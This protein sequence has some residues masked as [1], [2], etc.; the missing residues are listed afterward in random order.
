MN[1]RLG[2]WDIPYIDPPFQ[3]DADGARW[4]KVTTLASEAS[5][6]KVIHAVNQ[7]LHDDDLC[8]PKELAVQK[9]PKALVD[10]ENGKCWHKKVQAA[11]VI[12]D[13]AASNVVT[14][15]GAWQDH[16]FIYVVMEYCSKVIGEREVRDLYTAVACGAIPWTE[17]DRRRA[18]RQMLLALGSLHS[19][20]LTHPELRLHHFLLSSTGSIKLAG[21][22]STS[23]IEVPVSAGPAG[24]A[25]GKKLD[26][27]KLGVALFA[28]FF[29]QRP[30][31]SMRLS[32]SSVPE[33][34]AEDFVT[35][36]MHREP[37][38]RPSVESAL[39]HPWLA[40]TAQAIGMRD[41]G[42]ECPSEL[43]WAAGLALGGQ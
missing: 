1:P 29:G 5:G 6:V 39:V 21:L 32:S 18:A 11:L 15:Y 34:S 26:M 33:A 42:I 9:V 19:S 20:G 22:T 17:D 3:R 23:S 35:R 24:S 31:P 7:R 14:Y 8:L 30:H 2:I 27:F 36:L 41:D 16:E 38:L 28:L 40:S 25:D 37:S 10:R 43:I 4:R 12:R 13:W